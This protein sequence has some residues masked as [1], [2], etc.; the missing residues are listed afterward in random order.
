MLGGLFLSAD[1]TAVTFI[2][3]SLKCL[4]EAQEELSS[5]VVS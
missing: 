4:S 3:V 1:S 5:A 2:L